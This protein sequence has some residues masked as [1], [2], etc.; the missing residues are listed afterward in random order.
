[1]VV[2]GDASDQQVEMHSTPK[3]LVEHIAEYRIRAQ[4]LEDSNPARSS[5]ALELLSQAHAIAVNI[6]SGAVSVDQLDVH[7]KKAADLMA[8]ALQ[9]VGEKAVNI[10]TSSKS[11]SKKEKSIADAV[12]KANVGFGYTEADGTKRSF[13]AEAYGK[14]SF[15]NEGTNPAIG[16]DGWAVGTKLSAKSV[17]NEGDTTLTNTTAAGGEYGSKGLSANL[18]QAWKSEP[19]MKMEALLVKPIPSVQKEPRTVL[20]V[21]LS[22]KMCSPKTRRNLRVGLN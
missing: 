2:T 12:A 4:A 5:K 20:V 14:T 3:P 21:P 6:D 1:M 19:K 13:D 11:S 10:E 17:R 18:S 7:K 15:S 8:Q 22:V 9:F 16:N